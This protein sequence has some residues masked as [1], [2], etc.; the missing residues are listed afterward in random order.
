VCSAGLRRRALSVSRITQM[1]LVQ[2][3]TGS[4]DRGA[5]LAPEFALSQ[6]LWCAAV[7]SAEA[8]AVNLLPLAAGVRTEATRARAFACA[9]SSADRWRKTVLDTAAVQVFIIS[10][11]LAHARAAAPWASTSIPTP[12]GV[13]GKFLRNGVAGEF[14]ESGRARFHGRPCGRKYLANR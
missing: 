2:T 8:D 13:Q 6:R 4:P 10:H 9:G 7:H 12:C 1:S 11:R 3:R 14:L 5:T